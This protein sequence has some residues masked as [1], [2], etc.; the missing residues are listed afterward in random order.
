MNDSG[1]TQLFRLV[2]SH[3][4]AMSMICLAALVFGMVS[5]QRLAIE[6]MPDLSYPTITSTHTTICSRSIYPATHIPTSSHLASTAPT[7]IPHTNHTHTP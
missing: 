2:V 5:Y 1:L 6:L 7:H 3:P 4:V